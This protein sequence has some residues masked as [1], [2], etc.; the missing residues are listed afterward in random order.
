VYVSTAGV[1]DGEKA[2]PYTED[3]QPRPINVYGRTKFEGERLVQQLLSTSYL[4]R[5]G[6][7]MGGGAVDKKFVHKIINQLEAGA[8]VI[9]AVVD[10]Y[11]TPTYAPDFS[12]CLIEIV[13]RRLYGTYHMACTGWGTRYDVA[14][15]ILEFL[16]RDDV[17]LEAVTSDYFARDYPARRP[18]SEIM[19]NR[20]LDLVGLNWMRPWQVALR[21]YLEQNFRDCRAALQRVEVA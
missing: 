14:A 11:G 18:K 13:Q 16:G 10:K 21:E 15:A 4:V 5:A 20:M 6:W 2:A 7:M 1:F 3:D 12:R 9:H 19:E 17:R 8:T